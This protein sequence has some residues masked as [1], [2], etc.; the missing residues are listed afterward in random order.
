MLNQRV[1]TRTE[2][3]I[4]SWSLQTLLRIFLALV[5]LFVLGC[6]Y[7]SQVNAITSIR[8][9]TARLQQQAAELERENV[10]LMVQV[11]AYTRPSSVQAQAV[12]LG[13]LA[14]PR[15]VYVTLPASDGSPER[16]SRAPALVAWWQE[17]VSSLAQRWP[18]K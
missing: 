9:Q 10:S 2:P 5:M 11:A 12:D 6:L 8:I 14:M 13:L 4:E 18:V 15:P 16:L 3:R 1:I 17:V 7:F